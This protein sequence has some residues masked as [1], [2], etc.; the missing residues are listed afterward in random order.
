VDAVVTDPPY[1]IKFQRGAGGKGRWTHRHHEVI[2][3]DTEPFD[4]RPLLHFPDVILW[5]ANH[6]A[7]QLPNSAGWLIWDKKLGLKDD[8]FSDCEIAWHKHGTRSRIFRY[9]WNGL[10]AHEPREKRLHVM[11]KPIA[12]FAWCLGFLTGQRILDPFMGSGTCGIACIQTGKSYIG[13]EIDPHSF[14]IACRRIEQA[15]AQPDL[16]VPHPA[17]PHQARLFA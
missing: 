14:T 7:H 13:I 3:G 8:D 11:Q 4:P 1:G 12:L 17:P 10:L 2:N 16:F 9:L 15:Y 5:G 6:Y